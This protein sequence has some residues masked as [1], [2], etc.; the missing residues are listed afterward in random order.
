MEGIEYEQFVRAVLVKRLNLP[1]ESLISSREAGLTFPGNPKLIHQI[2]LIYREETDVAEYITIVECKYR[3]S[4][5][6]DQEEVAKLAFA[7]SSI[8][9]SKA[10]LVTNIGFTK[11]ADSL[12]ASEKI[13]LLKI[14]PHIETPIKADYKNSNELF[15]IFT[16][17]LK[18]SK[19]PHEVVVCR[20][21]V[22]GPDEGGTDLISSLLKDPEVRIIAEGALKNPEI[23]K[24][25]D[26]FL[27]DN[28]DIVRKGIDVLKGWK[29]F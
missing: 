25:A 28:P 9:A 11:G 18:K 3:K 7:K 22:A 15:S 17:K 16:Q 29:G 4:A 23:R 2:D 8:K 12:A 21:L 6:V 24:A 26:E 27:R 1:P 14:V 5:K 10:I 13:A 20:K 19:S